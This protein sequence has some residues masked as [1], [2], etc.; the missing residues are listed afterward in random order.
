MKNR[1][2]NILEELL[3]A[4]I[5][6]MGIIEYKMVYHSKM[7]VII[8]ADGTA[9]CIA[10]NEIKTKLY[11]FTCKAKV[12]FDYI[13]SFED[14]YNVIINERIVIINRKDKFVNLKLSEF[15]IED[16]DTEF[17]EPAEIY[18]TNTYYINC[19]KELINGYMKSKINIGG[20]HEN[21]TVKLYCPDNA[22][23]AYADI[24]LGD[25][26]LKDLCV[27]NLQREYLYKKF[28][29]MKL[30]GMFLP[31]YQEERTIDNTS[32]F[33]N[34][35]RIRLHLLTTVTVDDVM[36]YKKQILDY[37]KYCFINMKAENKYLVQYLKIVDI[38]LLNTKE[39]V[40]TFMYKGDK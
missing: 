2:K 34:I 8:Y 24:I 25:Q 29:F 7:Y 36:K 1:A 10:Y 15:V 6:N 35:Y 16:C 31:D 39:L 3:A 9:D 19:G 17:K 23:G 11:R 21:V 14:E 32:K 37:A 5:N 4:S 20:K 40:I 27:R 12:L 38:I 22:Y 18:G 33:C 26:I 30:V 28:G 13:V